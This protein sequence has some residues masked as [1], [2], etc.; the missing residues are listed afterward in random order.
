M[1]KISPCATEIWES[2]SN[3]VCLLTL[4]GATNHKSAIS[5]HVWKKCGLI[6][7]WILSP[8]SP[9]GLIQCEKGSTKPTKFFYF[10]IT[11]KFTPAASTTSTSKQSILPLS[12]SA[13]SSTATAGATGA[14]LQRIIQIIWYSNSWDQIILFVFG[15]QSICNFRIVFEYPNSCYQITNSYRLFI[16]QNVYQK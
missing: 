16:K 8:P 1:F 4:F 12:S 11:S 10:S 14:E 6:Q 13:T 5:H 2:F 15:I 3:S 7:S 9:I